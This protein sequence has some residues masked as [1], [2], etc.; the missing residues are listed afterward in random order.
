MLKAF[1]D[2]LFFRGFFSSWFG[3]CFRFDGFDWNRSL[4]FF[5]F[6]LLSEFLATSTAS[7]EFRRI[8]LR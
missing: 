4:E 5:G 7:L 3:W 2:F 6:F 1:F 8:R